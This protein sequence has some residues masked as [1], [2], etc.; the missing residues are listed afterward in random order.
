[1]HRFL[2]YTFLASATCL[3]ASSTLKADKPA[4]LISNA[5]EVAAEI[6]VDLDTEVGEMYNFWDVYP[7]TDQSP[8]LDDQQFDQLKQTYRYAKYI[9]CVRLL[10]GKE[11]KKDD[12][13]RGVDDK[14][15]AV[16]DFSEALAMLA[17]IRKCGFT[18]WIVLDNVPAKLSENP[19]QNRYGNTEPPA[20]FDLW[21]SYVRQFA[22]SLVDKFGSEDVCTWRFRVGTEP[23]FNP[24]HWTGTKQQYLQHYDYTVAAV[25]SVLPNVDI[26]PGNVVAPLRGRKDKSW[27]PSIINHCAT[28]TNYITGQTGTPLRFFGSSYYTTVGKADKQFD[29]VVNFLRGKI[30]SHPQLANAASELPIEIQE[31]GILS[32]GGERIIGDGTEFGGSWLSHMADKIYQ[33]RVRRAYQWSWNT[34]KGGDLP[35]PITHVMDMLEEMDGGTRLST[36][37]SR[38][39]EEE[40][41]GCIAAKKGDRVDLMVFRHLAVRDNGNKVPVRLTL[42]GDLLAKKNWTLSRANV[43]DGEHAGFMSQRDV[44][45]KQARTEAGNGAKHTAIASKVMTAQV[46]TAHRSKYEKMSEL[47][48]LDPPPTASTDASGQIHFDLMM[49]GHTV[50]FLRLE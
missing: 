50:V 48:S 28:G 35:T 7:V 32:E 27:A 6:V 9:N 12:Y 14:G 25:Q 43:I 29:Q 11:L 42:S 15:Q 36:A 10:G 33:N 2:S 46:M 1:M 23:D 37:A 5:T 30:D 13:F 8:F 44:D 21:S 24:G 26:G 4:G 40:R 45:I 19:T 16:C 18:P 39:S 22:Q 20:D 47:H 34:N 49:D 31:F 3:L 41:L 17:G 38:T